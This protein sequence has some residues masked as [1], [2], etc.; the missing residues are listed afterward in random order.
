MEF[1]EFFAVAWSRA[2]RTTYAVAGRCPLAEAA[3]ERAFADAYADW[4]GLQEYDDPEEEV[5][6][7]AIRSVLTAFRKSPDEFA[8]PAP[9]FGPLNPHGSLTAANPEERAR[10]DDLWTEFQALEPGDRAEI[11]LAATSRHTAPE[12]ESGTS[13]TRTRFLLFLTHHLGE[14][15][16]PAGDADSIVSRGS[17]RRRRRTLIATAVAVIL[18]ALVAVPAVLFFPQDEPASGKNVG[19][20]REGPLAPL[21]PRWSALSA[22]TGTEALFIGGVSQESCAERLFCKGLRDG[23]AYNPETGAWR[24]IARAPFQITQDAPHAHFGDQLFIA[25]PHWVKYD[26]SDDEWTRLPP[27][28]VAYSDG[29]LAALGGS[30]YSVG[31]RASDPIQVFNGSTDQWSTLQTDSSAPRLRSRNLIGTS[32]GLVVVGGLAT[33]PAGDPLGA[34][35]LDAAVFD[36]RTWTPLP[37]GGQRGSSRRWSWTG[38]RLLHPEIVAVLGTDAR[39]VGVR[40]AGGL[41]LEPDTGKWGFLPEAPDY[42]LGVNTWRLYADGGPLIAADGAVFDDRSASWARLTRPAQAPEQAVAA[43]WADGQLLAFGGANFGDG[44]NEYAGSTNR[45]WIYTPRDPTN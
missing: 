4:R 36:G 11:A 2:Y 40:F 9:E 42:D 1:A 6:A 24:P 44:D 25:D 29:P 37:S 17:A 20:W 38:E 32:H 7:N 34:L 21:S 19:V 31:S 23:A 18:L 39:P 43:V 8:S 41:T 3:T 22:W 26:A 45:L 10:V 28:P 30:I 27:P 35:D 16:V 33:K 14:I 13:P 15:L 5:T 12:S